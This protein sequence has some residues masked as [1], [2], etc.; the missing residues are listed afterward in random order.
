MINLLNYSMCHQKVTQVSQGHS[1]VKVSSIVIRV[2][3]WDQSTH[4]WYAV[5]DK[6]QTAYNVMS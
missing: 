1:D 2:A 6:N 5:S 4:V 3:N